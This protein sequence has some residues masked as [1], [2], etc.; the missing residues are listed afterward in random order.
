MSKYVY[1][2]YKL[3]HGILKHL[4]RNEIS[5]VILLFFIFVLFFYLELLLKFLCCQII[6]MF[7]YTY[8]EII[9]IN[10]SRTR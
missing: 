3:S 10:V 6:N 7:I 4:F 9:V 2:I 8:C 5:I 1:S